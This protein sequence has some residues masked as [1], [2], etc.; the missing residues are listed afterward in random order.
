MAVLSDQRA[1]KYYYNGK[2]YSIEENDGTFQIIEKELIYCKQ[3]PCIPPITGIFQITDKK[4]CSDLKVFLDDLLP[5]KKIK[6]KAVYNQKLTNEQKEIISNILV[7]NKIIT[8]IEYEI[9]KNLPLDDARY[10]QRGFLTEDKDSKAICTIAM[11]EQPTGGYSITVQKVKINRNKVIIYVK[12]KSPGPHE[13]VNRA[14]TFPIAQVIFNHIP[15]K[16]MVL[17]YDTDERYE[18]LN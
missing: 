8:I 1:I 2:I 10:N 7:N 16:I 15:D 6:V 9:V 3:A 17:D 12:E 18:I 5:E 4:E 13:S 11:G 14:Q